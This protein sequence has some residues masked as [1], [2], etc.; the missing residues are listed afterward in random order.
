[1]NQA[2]VFYHFGR[3]VYRPAGEAPAGAADMR[4]DDAWVREPGTASAGTEMAPGTVAGA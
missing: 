4:W 3:K 1:M 2:L